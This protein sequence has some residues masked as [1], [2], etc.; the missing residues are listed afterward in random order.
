MTISCALA[1]SST[2]RPAATSGA[3]TADRY[4]TEELEDGLIVASSDGCQLFMMNGS[5][6]FVWERRMEGV[7]DAEIRA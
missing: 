3:M 4:I 6:R 1:G 2:A 7:I 5:A